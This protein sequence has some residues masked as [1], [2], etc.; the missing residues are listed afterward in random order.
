[1]HVGKT[2]QL[3]SP[4]ELEPIFSRILGVRDGIL[5]SYR[6]GRGSPNEVIGNEREIFIRN[7]LESAYPKPFRFSSGFITD[8][9]G[10]ISGQLDIIIEKLLS[11]S[12]PA[13]PGS[14]ERLFLAE[15][16]SAVISVKSNLF[17][18]WTQIE[19]ELEKLTPVNSEPSGFF[20]VNSRSGSLPFFIVSY[21]GAKSMDSLAQKLSALPTDSC[22]QAVVVLDA[23]IFA[24]QTAPGKWVYNNSNSAFF[25]FICQLHEEITRN[26]SVGESIFEYAC[27]ITKD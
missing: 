24:V 17:A 23:D 1:M 20:Q 11:T 7:Y 22:L 21:S 27:D 26:F 6:A 19:R 18:Q 15:M 10:N 12:F 2:I 3:G 4:K 8:K 13:Q 16:V 25:Y 5:A 14:S 9:S